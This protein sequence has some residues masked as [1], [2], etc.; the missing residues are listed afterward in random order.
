[1][2]S[3]ELVMK[4]PLADDMA[5]GLADDGKGVE[6]WMRKRGNRHLYIQGWRSLS[7]NEREILHEQSLGN[8]WIW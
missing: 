4:M 3:L 8:H 5:V 6:D 1:M 2:T 7:M